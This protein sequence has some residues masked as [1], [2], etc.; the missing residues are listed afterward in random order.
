L[1]HRPLADGRDVFESIGPADLV[2]DGG[3]R[4][5]ARLCR[6]SEA[7]EQVTLPRLVLDLASDG[8]KDLVVLAT[9]AEA[10]ADRQTEGRD[11]AIEALLASVAGALLDHQRQRTYRSEVHAVLADQGQAQDQ[12]ARLAWQLLEHHREHPSPTRRPRVRRS[13]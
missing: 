1:L 8:Q 5:Y 9:G 12:K 7:G 3:R 11:E 6:Y 2:T 4:L 13:R 10:D